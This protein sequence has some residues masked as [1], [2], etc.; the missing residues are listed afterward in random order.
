MSLQNSIASVRRQSS[1][2]TAALVLWLGAAV[3]GCGG[4]SGASSGSGGTGG[5]SGGTGG[6]SGGGGAA[7]GC[8]PA[9]A[10]VPSA[11]TVTVDIE[12]TTAADRYVLTACQDCET[13]LVEKQGDFGYISESLILTAAE[14]CGCECP[15]PPPGY[16]LGYHR[17][18]AGD[19]Y[20]ARWDAR[21]LLK[22]DNA[23]D[24]GGGS[25][26]TITTGALQP[27]GPGE[28]RI[29][30]GI[31]EKLPPECTQTGATDD[32]ACTQ[33]PQQGINPG[34]GFFPVELTL[35]ESGDVSAKLT[36]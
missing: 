34:G 19:T 26:A 11:Q 7:M 2:S 3:A 32:F 16:P 1:F 27:A 13:L 17:V 35:P 24:C 15:A 33:P 22:C 12:N 30:Y 28:Y 31:V 36:L 23:Q 21:T 14:S 4:G 25:T 18:K 20:P 8:D 29:S 9:P 5:G 10:E 6:G